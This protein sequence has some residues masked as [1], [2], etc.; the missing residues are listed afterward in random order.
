MKKYLGYLAAA[1]VAVAISSC[2]KEVVTAD[3]GDKS[4]AAIGVMDAARINSSAKVTKSLSKQKDAALEK[5]QG[6]VDKKRKDFESKET[7]LKSKQL[8]LGQEAFMKEASA[9]RNELIEYD[10][11]TAARVA[12]REKGYVEGLSKIQKDY[13]DDIVRKIGRAKGYDIVVNSQAAILLNADLDITDEVIKELDAKV[14]EIR[15]K[16]E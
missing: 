15:L 9:F 13:L 11:A 8:I 10:R 14:S 5:V 12:A 1:V 16:A 6:E 7:E 3:T 2:T 4:G